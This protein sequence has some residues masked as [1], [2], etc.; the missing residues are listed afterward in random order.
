M[1]GKYWNF[2]LLLIILG[3]MSGNANPQKSKHHYYLMRIFETNTRFYVLDCGREVQDRGFANPK[4]S[5]GNT[6][7]RQLTVSL[8]VIDQN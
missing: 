8:T 4:I 7:K 6:V 1:I 2:L 3:I 5:V